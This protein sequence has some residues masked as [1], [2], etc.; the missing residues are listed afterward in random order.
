[1]IE[2]NI[3]WVQV[4]TFVVAILLPLLV[5]LVTKVVTRPGVRAV[6]LALLSAAAGLLSE[7]VTALTTGQTY[8]LGAALIL[9]V[10]I[11]VVA[12]ATH[13]GLWKPTGASENAKQALG[14]DAPPPDRAT[15]V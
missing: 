15:S 7:L 9:W 5:G 12:V 8:D 11:F 2:F 10:G 4:L 14:G 13:F 6:L 1:M 3:D